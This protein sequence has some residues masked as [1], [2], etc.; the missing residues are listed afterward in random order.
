MPQPEDHDERVAAD[1]S[2]TSPPRA[3]PMAFRLAELPTALGILAAH[4][5]RYRADRLRRYPLA[6]QARSRPHAGLDAH[7][8][9]PHPCPGGDHGRAAL[10]VLNPKVLFVCAAAGLAIGTDALGVVG[11]VTSATV[12]VAVAGSSVAIPIL[13]SVGAGARLDGPLERLKDWKEKHHAALVA[14]I[15]VL[16]GLVVLYKGIH[17]L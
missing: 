2:L 14:A 8:Y 11:T 3:V 9:Q 6:D 17:A 10:T 13:A 7:A 4:S 12:F 16:I 1:T 15:L 5:P